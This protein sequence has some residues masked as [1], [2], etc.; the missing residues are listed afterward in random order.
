M[1]NGNFCAGALFFFP[2]AYELFTGVELKRADRIVFGRYTVGAVGLI[3]LIALYSL[4]IKK[5]LLLSGRLK[6]LAVV[7]Y[8]LVFVY[9][10]KES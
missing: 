8:V 9:F 7:S 3:V 2:S 1:L 5:E 10:Y 6:F 4:V